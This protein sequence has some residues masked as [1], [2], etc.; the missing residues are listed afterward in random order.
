MAKGHNLGHPQKKCSPSVEPGLLP[1]PWPKAPRVNAPSDQNCPWPKDFGVARPSHS[2]KGVVLSGTIISSNPP[3]VSNP[4]STV[5]TS[6]DHGD[7]TSTHSLLSEMLLSAAPEAKSS[8]KV[9][10]G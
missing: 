7:I 1:R 5:H 10:G 6:S 4:V 2:S 8:A 9:A 3:M